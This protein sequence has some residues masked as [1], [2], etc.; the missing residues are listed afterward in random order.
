MNNTYSNTTQKIRLADIC[1]EIFKLIMQLRTFQDYSEFELL[2]KHIVS[3]LDRMEMEAKRNNYKSKDIQGAKFALIAFIDETIISSEWSQKETWTAKPLQL[4]IY[5]SFDAGEVFFKRLKE[6][7]SRPNDYIDLIEIYYLCLALGFKGK[8]GLKENE[9]L[10]VFT[11]DVFKDLK[12]T[13]GNKNLE[14]SPSKHPKDEKTDVKGKEI[15]VWVFGI[16]ATTI[17]LLF[18]LI[19]TVLSNNVADKVI[20]F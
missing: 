12:K 18:Y 3:L 1:S 11:E 10:K 17:G 19:M 2:R 7:R 4:Q 15:P 13:M 16:G 14:L 8:Y 20:E 6:F 9:N 5:D